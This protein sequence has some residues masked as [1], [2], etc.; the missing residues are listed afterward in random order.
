MTRR[1]NTLGQQLRDEWL[2]YYAAE[3][4]ECTPLGNVCQGC[5]HPGNPVYQATI[6][7]YWEELPPVNEIWEALVQAAKQ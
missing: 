3:P 7:E 4:C 1:L 2:K 6:A 5:A